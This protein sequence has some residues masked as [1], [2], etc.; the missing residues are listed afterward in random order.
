MSRQNLLPKPLCAFGLSDAKFS[1]CKMLLPLI[2]PLEQG[3]ERKLRGSDATC[4]HNTA[5]PR[6]EQALDKATIE[7]DIITMIMAWERQLITPEL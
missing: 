2:L 3:I 5:Q 1:I 7:N 6:T 4:M